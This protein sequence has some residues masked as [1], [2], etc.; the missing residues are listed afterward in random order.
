MLTTVEEGCRLRDDH[1]LSE[2]AKR[3]GTPLYVYDGDRIV[4]RFRKLRAAFDGYPAGVRF[5]YAMKA[6][7][8]LAIV[9]LLIKEGAHPECISGGEVALAKR[10]GCPGRDIL[11]TSSSKSPAELEVA[12]ADDVLINIDSFDE[13]GQVERVAARLGVVARV[14]F[15]VNPDVDPQTHRHIATG[16]K[17]TKFGLLLENEHYVEAF[18]RAGDSASVE[19]VGIQAHIGSQILTLEPFR[20][21]AT[22]LLDAYQTLLD[23]LDLRLSFVD[24][25]GGIGVRYRPEED[26]LDPK[27]IARTITEQFRERLGDEDLPELWFE[28]GRYFVGG[29]GVLL[30]RVHSVKHTPFRN[31]INVDTGFNQFIRPLLY[32]AYHHTRVVGSGPGA[33]D[34]LYDVAGNIC[35]TGDILAEDRVLPTPEAGDLMV[36]EGAG[37]Y[38]YTLASEYNSFPLPAE[39]LIRG[40]RIDLIRRRG[41]MDDLLRAQQWPSDLGPVPEGVLPIET[42]S[43]PKRG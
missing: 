22:L 33:D 29:S 21:N 12:C 9:Q 11:L 16:H 40:D 37:A 26:E 17:L 27:E 25:G 5:H 13:L 34:R 30:T 41:T 42:D 35:E 28:P 2:L 15:R 3:Y 38:G 36:F 18:R 23:R 14:S 7:T 4:D 31:F 43:F 39:V 1:L 24:L 19:P 6:N 10:L 32:E 20:R 8:N